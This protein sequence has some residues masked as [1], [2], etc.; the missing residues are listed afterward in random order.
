VLGSAHSGKLTLVGSLGRS[1]CLL[2]GQEHDVVGLVEPPSVGEFRTG[3]EQLPT[4]LPQRIQPDEPGQ[5]P[6]PGEF[7]R[8]MQ[9]ESRHGS[10]QGPGAHGAANQPTE[11]VFRLDRSASKPVFCC[12]LGVLDSQVSG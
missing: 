4:D 3:K 6:Q 10:A 5:L 11:R 8:A 7:S 1:P 2:Q 12:L 9:H